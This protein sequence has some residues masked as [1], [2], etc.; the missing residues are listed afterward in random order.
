MS[1]YR[2]HQVQDFNTRL[3]CESV[4][5]V[6]K[7]LYALAG[8]IGGAVSSAYGQAEPSIPVE[9]LTVAESSNFE[10]TSTS[11]EVETLVSRLTNLAPHIQNL[12]FGRTAEGRPMTV[13]IV[14]REPYTI[15]ERDARLRALVIANIHSGECDGKEAMLRLLRE[16]AF[17]PE[18]PWL[19]KMVLIIVPN[20]N[21]DGNDRMG[22]ANRPG[23]I[24]PQQ[25]MGM[26]ENA[27]HM[28]LN[29][30]FVKL[31][32]PE[33]RNLVALMDEVHPTLFIDCHTTNGSRHRYGLTYDIPHNP[34]TSTILRQFLR[35]R[36]MPAITTEMA[37]RGWLTFYYG[38][39]DGQ[40]RRWQT[41]GFEPRYS[42]EY[43][44]MRGHL[45]ILSE[46]Y[47]Y[48]SYRERIDVTHAFVSECLQFL[49][50]NADDVVGV[51]GEVEAEIAEADRR[52][53]PLPLALNARMAPVEGTFTLHAFQGEESHDYEI[54]L[55]NHY[56]P[57]VVTTVPQAYLIP[58]DMSR[59]ADR[60]RMHGIV[61]E[62]LIEPQELWVE[63]E[64]ITHLQRASQAFQKHNLVQLDTQAEKQLRRVPA[65][66]FVVRT[67]Q[68]LG[69]LACYLLEARSCDGLA[70]WNFL[71][72]LL[73]VNGEYP[74]WR[75]PNADSLPVRRVWQVPPRERLTLE[76]I[77]GPGNLLESLPKPVK[78]HPG[79][80]YYV[81]DQWGRPTFVDPE[82]GAFVSPRRG[83]RGGPDR[84]RRGLAGVLERR[85][86]EALP[87]VPREV[88]ASLA[89]GQRTESVDGNWFALTLGDLSVL[90]DAEQDRA[91]AIGQPG[92]AA[93]LISFSPD[94][95]FCVYVANGGL[96]AVDRQTWQS[97]EIAVRR[98]D[99]ELVGKLDWVYQ[100]ELYGRGNYYG[101]WISPDSREVAFLRLDESHVPRVPILNHL[102]WHGELE[103]MDYP[104]AGDPLPIA[105]LQIAT[106]EALQP[107]RDVE[108]PEDPEGQLMSH[109]SWG[110]HSGRLFIQTQNR[111]QTYLRLSAVARGGRQAEWLL[112]DA[113]P[114][115]IESPGKP[116]ELPN[117]DFIWLS[118]RDGHAH[119]YRYS[120]AGEVIEQLTAGNWQ[121]LGL[122]GIDPHGEWVYYRAN[123]F[124]PLG[125]QVFR[126]QLSSNQM[127]LLTPES[128]THDAEF[129]AD[130]NY[131][132]DNYS[133]MLRPNISVLR[134]VDGTFLRL[135]NVGHDDRLEYLAMRE[136]KL[137]RI[138]CDD[139]GVMDGQLILPPDFDSRRRYPVVV[140][141][142]AGAQAPRVRDAFG[143]KWY[144]FH[145]LLAQHGY[146]VWV[147][148]NRAASLRST[149]QAWSVHGQL[150][151]E[152]LADIE[153]GLDWLIAQG[154]V[155][156]QRIGIWGWSYGGY[157]TAYAMTHSNRF[158]CGISGA[159][160]TDWRNY[161]A[162]YTERLMGPPQ[163]NPQGYEQTSVVKAAGNLQGRLLLIHGAVDDNVH[164]GN[165][166][167]LAHELQA[168]GK[169]F[170]MQIY[171]ASQHGIVDP[172]RALHLRK[173][174]LEFFLENL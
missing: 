51:L 158:A 88:R 56:E 41:Y 73:E 30:D 46:S 23:Q 35:E 82:S 1:K 126:L 29:R 139:A 75:V 96:H 128:G 60:L 169:T 45:S 112:T 43:A 142:Y 39:P 49:Y 87:D 97:R 70:T 143:G 85:L 28:D 24:G 66:T 172:L 109:V 110:P 71:D 174:M 38:T 81:L 62:E 105:T 32:S 157:M 124:D 161:D 79:S 141:I 113:T 9:L 111:E 78:F 80:N 138:P 33:A 147:C 108:L 114:A 137:V 22:L 47:S 156:E 159:P 98:H 130:W 162:I 171:P 83:G 132:I 115:W 121:V 54:E 145:Q 65:E 69:R 125:A 173:T 148:D 89:G 8:L 72:D 27:Q 133:D 68:P 4:R 167:Q 149:E 123:R 107:T 104:K 163:N 166:L 58:A 92:R 3:F 90:V 2:W 160:V 93:E 136:P 55:W 164:L 94:S 144:L 36:M 152:E 102:T 122:Y 134:R 119:L 63:I 44:G 12:E 57:T 153:E 154:W 155:D 50:E 118:P 34:A 37:E 20:Y 15:G 170:Q 151:V 74:I 16:L 86:A 64:T 21:A 101:Y 67:A 18:H 146:V 31:D 150:G 135:L 59:V 61:L 42:T 106:L 6:A 7:F 76:K 165:T 91:L 10:A 116:H 25:G 168:A 13:A 129:S 53:Q 52:E 100:E 11:A 140:H 99:R 48:I 17:Q 131:F 19:D 77:D 40:N 14:S 26:R 95:R 127:E 117:G 84:D 103:W 5:H 120:A